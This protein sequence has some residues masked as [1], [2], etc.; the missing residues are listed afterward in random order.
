MNIV[1]EYNSIK[2]LVKNHSRYVET[3]WFVI[4]GAPSSGKTTSLSLLENAGYKINPDI[5][6]L[7]IEKSMENGRTSVEV[8]IDEKQLQ[9]AIFCLMVRN[10]LSLNKDDIILH[11]YSLPDNI[12]F[13]SIAN[14]PI[15]KEIFR[16]ATMFRFR[17]V[18]IF[19]PVDLLL[20]GVRTETRE[21]QWKLF[22][23]IKKCYADLGYKPIVVLKDTIENRHQF[24]LGRLPPI[25]N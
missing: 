11:D 14:L 2:N 1:N 15:P 13:L 4:T 12:P 8:R 18:F 7:Y 22:E 20:D 24:L 9:K 6:R 19:E 16:S 10:A 21:E 23:L 5:S 25:K 17:N 3:N